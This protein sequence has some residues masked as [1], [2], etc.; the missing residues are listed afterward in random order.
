M[1][2]SRTNTMWRRVKLAAVWAVLLSPA[3]GVQ[4]ADSGRIKDVAI[5][6]GTTLEPL[7]GY[8]IVVGLNGTG[9]SANAEMTMNSLA[10][11]LEKMDVTVDASALKPKNVASVMVTANLDPNANVGSRLD[12]TVS[13]V[14]D[15]SSLEGGILL[16][17]PLRAANGTVSVLGQGNISIGGFNIKSGEGNSFRKNHA[18]AGIIPN[19]GT[20]KVALQGS[21]VHDGKVSWLLNNPDF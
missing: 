5:L 8:G 21:F 9:D 7:V 1:N 17:T 19:G 16:M 6:D 4:A 3:T 20:V 10:T 2:K 14:N 13:S 12:L 18:Q 11:M 15:A